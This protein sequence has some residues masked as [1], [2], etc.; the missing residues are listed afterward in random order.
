MSGNSNPFQVTDREQPIWRYLSVPQLLS[1]LDQEALWFARADTF[2]DPYEGRL[3]QRDI[4]ELAPIH[5]VQLPAYLEV[6]NKASRWVGDIDRRSEIEAFRRSTFVNCWHQASA[7]RD[8]FWRGNLDSRQG[9]V[10]RSDIASLEDALAGYDETDVR[11]GEV[12][13]IDYQTERIAHRHD[14]APIVHKREAFSDERELRAV[15]VSFPNDKHPSYDNTTYGQHLELD[16]EGQRAGK[17]VPVDVGTLLHEVRTAPTA[18]GW[19][20]RSIDDV[21]GRYGYEVP[22]EQ[23]GLRIEEL[24]S[25]WADTRE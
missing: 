22:V 13:Y 6:L 19:L 21:I 8:L 20:R 24:D 12:Q 2:E 14:L 1:I 3:P 10:I 9:V 17:Y 11:F 18:S 25:R 4:D 16:W 7:E 23:S 5:E 15:V